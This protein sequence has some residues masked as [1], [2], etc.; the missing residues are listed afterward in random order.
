V[1]RYGVLVEESA[2]GA[3]ELASE[4]GGEDREEARSGSRDIMLKKLFYVEEREI[5]FVI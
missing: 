3:T 2:A 5:V 4:E 1:V